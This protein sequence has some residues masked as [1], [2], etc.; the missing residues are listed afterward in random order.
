MALT[1]ALRNVVDDPHA[2]GRMEAQAIERAKTF[3]WDAA[4]LATEEVL[5]AAVARGSR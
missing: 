2:R 3:T 1:E 4:A 5:A